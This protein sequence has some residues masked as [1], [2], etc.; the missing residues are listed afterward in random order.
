M[1]NTPDEAAPSPRR[2][3]DTEHADEVIEI[4]VL[5]LWDNDPA[6][7][8]DIFDFRPKLIP[9]DV[10][11]PSPKD[12]SAAEPAESSRSDEE[13]DHEKESESS[14][15][16]ETPANAEKG[17]TK[18]KAPESGKQTSSQASSTGKEKPPA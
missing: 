4:Q 5:Q 16:Q 18:D 7:D 6:N 15:S 10:E 2:V 13:T 9:A 1:S 8:D 14:A 12:S 17:S 11:V 3:P